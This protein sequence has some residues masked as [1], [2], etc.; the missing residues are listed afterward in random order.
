VED[1]YVTL[2]EKDGTSTRKHAIKDLNA[3]FY[4]M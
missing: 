3:T 2:T 1:M 4:G